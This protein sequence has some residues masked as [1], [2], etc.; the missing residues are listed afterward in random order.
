[1]NSYFLEAPSFDRQRERFLN[2]ARM[3]N[4]SMTEWLH[5]LKGPRG[6]T[7]VTDVAVL[8]DPQAPSRLVV[9]SGTHG[10][11]GFYGSDCQIALLDS[12]RIHGVPEGVSVV[13]VHLVNPWGTAWLRRVTEDNVDL[14]RNYV[15]FD[16]P[17]P[18]NAGY[19]SMHP[20]YL[21][22]ELEGPARSIADATLA[23]CIARDGNAAVMSVVE[24]GQYVHADGLFFGGREPAWSNRTLRAIMEKHVAD[25]QTAICFDLHTGAGAF[26]HPMLMAITAKAYPMLSRMQALYGPW[27]HTIVTSPSSTTDTGIAAT[28]TG[29]TLQAMLDQ[30]SDVDLMQFVI[31]CGTYDPAR[32]HRLLRDDHW[33]HLFGDPFDATGRRIKAALLEHFFPADTHWRELTALRAQQVFARAMSSLA[34][35]PPDKDAPD[36]STHPG[37]AP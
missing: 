21:C 32:S 31:E 16:R 18:A 26:G 4:A 8:G 5:P 35:T 1:M 15:A 19:E 37:I 17:L 14:N 28:A 13:I 2:A 12:L 6:E 3:A 10:V 34:S 23:A 33:L 24:A 11:E 29:Y 22:P 30:L 7:L 20:I 27:L 25:A 9:L 36:R